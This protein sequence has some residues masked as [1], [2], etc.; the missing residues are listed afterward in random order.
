M[1]GKKSTARGARKPVQ[2][3]RS[4]R[5]QKDLGPPDASKVRGGMTATDVNTSSRPSVPNVGGPR[6]IVPCV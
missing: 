1:S 4:R 2:S 6:L 5:A 3:K